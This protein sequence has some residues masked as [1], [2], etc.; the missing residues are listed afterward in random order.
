MSTWRKVG[1][2]LI[3]A[4]AA[5]GASWAANVWETG[6][7]S[8]GSWQP[9]PNSLLRDRWC[10][11]HGYFFLCD[12]KIIYNS[13]C[14]VSSGTTVS[15]EFPVPATV[16]GANVFSWWDTGRDDI[17]IAGIDVRCSGDAAGTWTAIEGSGVTFNHDA[18]YQST[19]YAK[20]RNEGGAPLAEH[21]VAVRLRFAQQ[22]NGS[23]AY[24]EVEVTGTFESELPTLP[25]E[26]LKWQCQTFSPGAWTPVASNLMNTCSHLLYNGSDS[27]SA[28]GYIIDGVMAK[29]NH[30]IPSNA[31]LT[32]Q[33]GR[34]IDELYE[35]RIFSWWNDSGLDGLPIARIE[36]QDAD[37]AWTVI[38]YADGAAD[39]GSG[40]S[41]SV[42][43]GGKGAGFVSLS[44]K[45]G[46]PLAE[47]VAALRMKFGLMG[48]GS[49]VAEAEVVGYNR[50]G[51]AV[52]NGAVVSASS[53]CWNV[54]WSAEL[55]SL[56][57]SDVATV[58]LWTSTNGAPWMLTDT[59]Q[60]SE[61]N[62]PF[63]LSYVYEEVNLN[64]DYRIEVV[65]TARGQTWCS[66][67]DVARIV[68]HDNA[69]YFWRREV[70]SGNWEDAAN[71]TNNLNDARLTWPTDKYTTAD[72]GDLGGAGPVRVTVASDKSCVLALTATNAH[73]TFVGAAGVKL[74]PESL[75]GALRG[76]N[77]FEVLTASF[78]PITIG[79]RSVLRLDRGAKGSTGNYSY[80]TGV[81]SRIEVLNESQYT[82][83]GYSYFANDAVILL[84]NGTYVPGFFQWGSSGSANAGHVVFRGTHPKLD[85]VG[86]AHNCAANSKTPNEIRFV[87]PG[88]NWRGYATTPFRESG[89]NSGHRFGAG[90]RFLVNVVAD[91]KAGKPAKS[92]DIRLI[93]DPSTYIKVDGNFTFEAYGRPME[94]GVPDVKGNYFYYT[95]DNSTNRTPKVAGSY[96]TSIWFHH[97]RKQAGY[98]IL[99]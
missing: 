12:R 67:S 71:W 1:C 72:F 97:E 84:D 27:T 2:C 66:T 61:V 15:W 43:G 3:A 36:V 9:D 24:P 80:L 65:N 6:K 87:L 89:V 79:D 68:N 92:L 53:V 85:N 14:Q 91:E 38:S 88:G 50:P 21:V 57:A 17:R 35:F 28:Y 32:W 31:E 45:D 10:S 81:E 37:G 42:D 76:T 8:T 5:F 86:A 70:A 77:T 20:L 22:E 51:G 56:G 75:T 48:A 39:Y 78:P 30:N 40:S 69:H 23:V 93:E 90:G 47:G 64:I 63:G 54:D 99:K 13:S 34:A 62:V 41:A 82:G 16:T 59:K 7:Y 74:A 49:R 18:T 83:G 26:E 94:V 58:N 33:F 46:K 11:N 55:S 98:L 44:R 73:V 52:L 29:G 96:P 95:Y 19:L 4:V 60:V 25:E